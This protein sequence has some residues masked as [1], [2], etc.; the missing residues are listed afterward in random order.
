MKTSVGPIVGL[1]SAAC[2]AVPAGTGTASA[3]ATSPAIGTASTASNAHTRTFDPVPPALRLV[4]TDKLTLG[5]SALAPTVGNAAIDGNELLQLA[6]FPYHNAFGIATAAAKTANTGLEV[7]L[8]PVSLAALVAQNKTEAIPESVSGVE[9]DVK[10]AVP[11][12]TQAVRHE[13]Q[14][15]QDL[16]EK[17]TDAINSGSSSD[18]MAAITD[19]RAAAAV[20]GNDLLALVTIPIHN[21]V[22][23]TNAVD[24]V[25][26]TGIQVALVPVSLAALVLM[27]K[28]ETIPA[29]LDTV[30]SNVVN[31]VPNFVK[32]IQSEVDY[33]RNLIQKVLG[34]TATG[35]STGDDTSTVEAAAK[36][37]TAAEEEATKGATDAAAPAKDETGKDS[38]TATPAANDGTA[39][40]A[41]DDTKAD[42]QDAGAE[43][44]SHPV[45][46]IRHLLDTVV[47]NAGR[48]DD[49]TT[50]NTDVNASHNNGSTVSNTTSDDQG[51][52]TSTSAGANHGASTGS[53]TSTAST[54]SKTST[55]T[56]SKASTAS[57]GSKASNASSNAGNKPGAHRALKNTKPGGAKH[58]AA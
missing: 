33:D 31:T 24:N 45:R 41:T 54:G 37:G 17:L 15:D 16:F 20:S 40:T 46:S 38:E 26:N 19:Q 30:Q 58:R 12:F 34:G 35:G 3:A 27:N 21:A 23:V 10:N 8:L 53:K 1:L 42:D 5:A 57:T 55:S 7:A 4:G 56:G 29:Y 49:D 44:P 18:M 13:L 6:T 52:S 51:G 36:T 9:T 22:G 32:A 28:T 11:D 48:G 25:V 14:Y 47:H 50:T 39:D 2:I 43:K